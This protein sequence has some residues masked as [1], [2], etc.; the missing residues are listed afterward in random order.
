MPFVV[1]REDHI[2]FVGHLV[3]SVNQIRVAADTV[4]VTEMAEPAI[5]QTPAT[6][7]PHGCAR[8]VATLTTGTHDLRHDRSSRLTWFSVL[9]WRERLAA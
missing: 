4:A 2:R 6:T 7:I 8:I 3:T 9:L 5:P 1:R